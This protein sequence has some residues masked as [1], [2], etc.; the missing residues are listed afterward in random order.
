[1]AVEGNA[2]GIDVAEPAE[3]LVGHVGALYVV[4]ARAGL[5]LVPGPAD[6][7]ALG[8]GVVHGDADEPPLHHRWCDERR[9][10]R[11]VATRAVAQDHRRKWAGTARLEEHAAEIVPRAVDGAAEGPGRAPLRFRVAD[12]AKAVLLVRRHSLPRAHRAGAAHEKQCQRETEEQ[13]TLSRE[14]ASHIVDDPAVAIDVTGTATS[15]WRSIQ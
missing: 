12:D 8:M 11:R 2:L 13:L 1:M 15:R 10:P 5:A 14:D 7:H 3:D 9:E 4:L 6:R